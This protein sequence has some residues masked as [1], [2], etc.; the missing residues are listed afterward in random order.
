M[1]NK[2]KN[3]YA[4]KSRWH[5]KVV[6][7]LSPGRKIAQSQSADKMHCSP[8]FVVM[9]GDWAAST[10]AKKKQT[11]SAKVAWYTFFC[12]RIQC[13]LISM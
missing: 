7:S 3:Q 11:H 5:N 1:G 9:D 4:A 12:I 13:E 10:P 8:R 6:A 2:D